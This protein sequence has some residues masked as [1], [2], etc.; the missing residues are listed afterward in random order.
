MGVQPQ[1]RL[2]SLTAPAVLVAYCMLVHALLSG[3]GPWNGATP[4]AEPAVDS[5]QQQLSWEP[6]AA[7]VEPHGYELREHFVTTP[8]R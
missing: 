6:M 2:A 4:S 1:N 5:T 7:L 3:M 8:G